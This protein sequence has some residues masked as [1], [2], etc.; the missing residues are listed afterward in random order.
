METIPKADTAH[1]IKEKD[2]EP[3]TVKKMRKLYEAGCTSKKLRLPFTPWYDDS[4]LSSAP[5]Q[6][7]HFIK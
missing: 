5:K 6:V 2:R 1:L 4:V 7:T 3:R